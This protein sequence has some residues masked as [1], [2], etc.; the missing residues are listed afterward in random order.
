[1]LIG[2]SPQLDFVLSVEE[3][4]HLLLPLL[5]HTLRLEEQEAVVLEGEEEP[6]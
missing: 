6:A 1:M 3:A 2:D 4:A 5:H